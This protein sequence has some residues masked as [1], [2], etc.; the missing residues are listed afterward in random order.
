MEAED[1]DKESGISHIG[2]IQ[3]NAL[4]LAWMIENRPDMD[5][6]FKENINKPSFKDIQNS[7]AIMAETQLKQEDFEIQEGENID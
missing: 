3:C 7:L 6:R 4:F 5:D 2:H 1:N